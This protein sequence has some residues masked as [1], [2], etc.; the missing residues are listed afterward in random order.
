MA[1]HWK[2]GSGELPAILFVD[3]TGAARTYNV[4]ERKGGPCPECKLPVDQV[5]AF[6]PTDSYDYFHCPG[7]GVWL[8]WCDE[9]GNMADL[10]IVKSTKTTDVDENVDFPTYT[11]T[12]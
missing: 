10:K 7:C 11:G 2:T 1:A 4:Q 12:F 3:G 6:N 9:D 5:L 8:R